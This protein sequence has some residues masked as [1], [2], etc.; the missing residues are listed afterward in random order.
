M[1]K[2]S[3]EGGKMSLT[4]LISSGIFFFCLLL[5]FYLFASNPSTPNSGF[6]KPGV[7]SIGNP[8]ETFPNESPGKSSL[9][10]KVVK[11]PM[12]PKETFLASLENPE[13]FANR[14]DGENPFLYQ[15]FR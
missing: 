12:T 3:M 8:N 1:K 4:A 2:A 13:V 9:N 6:V 15:Y 5:F 11:S 14:P 10:K 7:L